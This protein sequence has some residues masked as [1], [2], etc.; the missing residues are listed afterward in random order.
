MTG[1]QKIQAAFCREGSPE[2]AAV[3]PYDEL[4]V[5]DRW[6]D[7]TSCPWWYLYEPSPDHQMQWRFD[8]FNK[9]GQDWFRIPTFYS[10]DDQ[11]NIRFV[12]KESGVFRSDLRDGSESR[13]ERPTIGGWSANGQVESVR[14]EQPLDTP[15]DIDRLLSEFPRMQCQQ[16]QWN[17]KD[18]LVQ[19]M[20]HS[21]GQQQYPIFYLSSPLWL[22]YGLWG[23][24]DLM[25]NI[26]TRPELVD[27]ACRQLL[28]YCVDTVHK[29]ASL[30]AEAIWIEECL[31][32][33][34][35]PEAFRHF[36]VPFMSQLVD[37][38]RSAGMKSIYYFCGNPAGK[39]DHILSVG[40]DAL[41]LEESKK[42][43]IIDIEDVVDIVRGRCTVLGNIDSVGIIQDGTEDELRSEIKRQLA[44]G[45]RNNNRF[46]MS[47]GSPI[48][49]L[50]PMDRVRLYC[51]M[52]HEL[53]VSCK[54]A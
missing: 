54:A 37:E 49:P 46:I 40:A 18:S 2:I 21:F 43:F 50:T 4:Y 12:S 28:H 5:R 52:V 27:Y 39:W 3:I 31:T 53:C 22:C 33:Q 34:I 35:S 14:P 38:I 13:I 29:A 45:R 30:G 7:L 11:A 23:F 6:D 48:T 9:L 1:R 44:V 41:A 25:T 19:L 32:D 16:V 42:G 8:I 20:L 15:E 24:E 36:N 51:D 17:G 26:I 47:L 10:N